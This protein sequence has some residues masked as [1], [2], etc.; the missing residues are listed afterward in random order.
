MRRARAT[1][2]GTYALARAA[3]PSTILGQGMKADLVRRSWFR[4]NFM[5]E[6]GHPVDQIARTTGPRGA[7]TIAA[8]LDRPHALPT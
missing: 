3:I 2:K 6:D 8:R 4:E 5:P 7:T 1:G